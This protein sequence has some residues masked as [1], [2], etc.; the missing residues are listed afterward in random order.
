MRIPI[1]LPAWKSLQAHAAATRELPMRDLF[2][3]DPKRAETLSLR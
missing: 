1:D 2:A 3:R